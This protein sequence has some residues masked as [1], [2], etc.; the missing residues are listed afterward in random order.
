[1]NDAPHEHVRIR[2][3]TPL[4]GRVRI[5]GDLPV[6][7]RALL[8]GALGG[9]RSELQAVPQSELVTRS[10]EA[11]RALGVDC[12]QE[13]ERVTI[14]G[15]GLHGLR[16]PSGALAADRS[17]GALA[18]LAGLLSAQA[19]GT[20]ITVHP[21][22]ARRSVEQIVAPLRARGAQI[23]AQTQADASL[24]PIAVAPLL[25][26]E[27][28]LGLDGSLP[29]S[30]ADAKTAILISGLY[31]AGPTT[32]SEPQLSADHTER[33]MVALD[34]PL[35]RIGTVVAFDPTGWDHTIA[36]LGTLGLP[37]SPTIAAYLAC[38]AQLLPGSDITLVNVGLNP[39]RA[40]AIE[41]LRSW[42][43]ALTIAPRGD[44]ALREPVA[45]LRIQSGAL[46]GGVVGG[47][48]LAR[49]SDELPAL[50][51]LGAVAK[52]GVRLCD[53]GW[54]G[55]EP[56]PSWSALDPLF[57]AFGL[58]VVREP[59]E[60]FVCGPA[61][62][63]SASVPRHVDASDDPRLALCACTLALATAGETVVE[64]AAR[65][66]AS[67]YPGFMEAAHALG[68]DIQFV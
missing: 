12:R 52:R 38:A 37:G 10:L 39:S 36:P 42:A 58:Q 45:D 56:D 7:Q 67:A 30:D 15:V 41:L 31:A 33:M 40:G 9:G 34:L 55:A 43:A 57:A 68:A 11:W 16:M 17:M 63:L 59:G 49:A 32:V 4:R 61:E 5:A 3:G 46:R 35:R 29:W 1:V 48:L 64:H 21:T 23:A 2:G 66:L 51:L 27:K 18:Q 26:E 6:L 65:A 14:D 28:L 8:F 25:A 53:L 13:A 20:R 62:K 44:A 54:L 24:A 60:L 22:L 50:A 47:E 19:F